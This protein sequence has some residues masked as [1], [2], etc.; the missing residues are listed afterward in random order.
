MNDYHNCYNYS[1]ICSIYKFSKMKNWSVTT[2]NFTTLWSY[3]NPLLNHRCWW[4]VSST[5][6]LTK[7]VHHFL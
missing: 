2:Y 1:N 5:R 7:K 6:F 4:W 3:N